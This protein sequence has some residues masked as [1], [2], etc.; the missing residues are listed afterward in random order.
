VAGRLVE[1]LR[2]GT[3]SAW[4]PV[5]IRLRTRIAWSR[6]SVREDAHG[7]MSFL[8]ERRRPEADL[9]RAARGYVVQMVRRAELR[10][11]PDLALRVRVEGAEHLHAAL[12]LG[13]G[14]VV[15][16]VH[17]GLYD[18]AFPSIARTG[19]PLRMMVHPYMLRDDAPR[20]LKQHVRINCSGGGTAV[21]TDVGTQ[22]IVGLLAAGDVVAIASDVPGRTPVTFAGREL[23]GSFGAARIA[24]DTDAPVVLM[25]SERDAAGEHVRLHPALVPRE[26]GSPRELLEAM[27]TAHEQAV[28]AWPEAGDLPRSRWGTPAADLAEAR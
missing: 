11:H 20:W 17:H 24:W 18:R 28:L 23:L 22:G 21:S 13:R 27:L 2:R 16:F 26:L 5:V 7:Q 4:L 15:S 8:L 12:D 19:V 9:T 10:W 1:R 14:A 3:P 25:T 6:P